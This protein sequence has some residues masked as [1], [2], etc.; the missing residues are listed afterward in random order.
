MSSPQCAS[1]MRDSTE[2]SNICS[3]SR[4]IQLTRHSCLKTS[5]MSN[6]FYSTYS[7][8]ELVKKARQT[9]R[10]S[11]GINQDNYIIAIAP[12]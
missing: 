12:G 1:V 9:F 10:Q 7:V 8:S 3:N 2:R 6:G 11:K 5:P 4:R